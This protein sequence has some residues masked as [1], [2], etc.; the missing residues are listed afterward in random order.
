MANFEFKVE[1]IFLFISNRIFLSL[2]FLT[3]ARNLNANILLAKCCK[4]KEQKHTLQIHAVHKLKVGVECSVPLQ[5]L[6]WILFELVSSRN[7]RNKI[8][9]VKHATQK[10]KPTKY[11]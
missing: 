1:N 9:I 8:Q 2:C 10:Q 4:E 6:L 7:Q 5:P 11:K 3:R